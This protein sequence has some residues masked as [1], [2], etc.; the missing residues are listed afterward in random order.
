MPFACLYVEGIAVL[1]Q[2]LTRAWPPLAR[3]APVA[4]V[5]VIVAVVSFDEVRLNAPAFASAYNWFGL[6]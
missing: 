4:A 5:A 3:W 2:P 6:P 1:L